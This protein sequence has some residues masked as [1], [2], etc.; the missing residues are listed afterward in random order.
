MLSSKLNT[1]ITSL[2]VIRAIIQST[3]GILHAGMHEVA[4]L[5]MQLV[6]IA[7]HT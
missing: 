1:S 3:R 2:H 4:S 7:A 6:H 5:I